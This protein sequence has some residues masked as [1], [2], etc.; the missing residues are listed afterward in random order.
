MTEIS[1]SMKNLW[2]YADGTG[3][4]YE[5]SGIT[6]DSSIS[7]EQIKKK[8]NDIFENKKTAPSLV[9]TAKILKE[10]FK[11]VKENSLQISTL[12]IDK[13]QKYYE[14]ACYR[15]GNLSNYNYHQYPK[16]DKKGDITLDYNCTPIKGIQTNFFAT[17]V[18]SKQCTIEEYSTIF[19]KCINTLNQ[20]RNL[21][22]SE[23]DKRIITI[24]RLFYQENPNFN[25]QEH[26]I[27][28]IAMLTFLKEF[29]ILAPRDKDDYYTFNLSNNFSLL[30]SPKLTLDLQNLALLGEV[31]EEMS[32]IEL[33]DWEYQT[34]TK[35]GQEI[36]KHMKEQEFPI[37]WFVNL[38]RI[39][40]IKTYC[41]LSQNPSQKI[42]MYSNCPEE[43][44]NKYLR[45][46]RKIEE[47]IKS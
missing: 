3:I 18:F 36:R 40:Y 2:E 45:L 34:I 10:C 17:D 22:L 13:E 30:S 46:V 43:K 38:V 26:R 11:E 23:Y 47:Q 14:G 33:P 35:V 1:I 31:T 20:L 7:K 29:G 37:A 5:F 21:T 42:A 15:Q 41:L 6:K 8:L 9:E 27:K 4:E 16:E 19:S 44:V 24:Y 28:T 12:G 39:N 25:S 32:S